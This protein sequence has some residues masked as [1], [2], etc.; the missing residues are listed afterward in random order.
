MGYGHINSVDLA[1]N[2][3]NM[4]S[5][6]LVPHCGERQNVNSEPMV[7]APGSNNHTQYADTPRTVSQHSEPA[8]GERM[9]AINKPEERAYNK[10]DLDRFVGQPLIKKAQENY[11]PM[12]MQPFFVQDRATSISEIAST[13]DSKL[14]IVTFNCKNVN[15][16]EPV[17]NEISKFADIVLIQ[18]QWLFDCNLHKMKK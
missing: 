10:T 4:V 16:C 8:T 7:W 1:R 11:P 2:N 6:H 3:I 13:C 18:E 17:Y 5:Q 9:N 14:N 15:T 12:P